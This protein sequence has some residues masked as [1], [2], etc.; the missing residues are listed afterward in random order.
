MLL[1]I[2]VYVCLLNMG[3]VV[4][5]ETTEYLEFDCRR[6]KRNL[7]RFQFIKDLGNGMA[8]VRN[9]NSKSGKTFEV[10]ITNFMM[11]PQS[12][13]TINK[14]PTQH[15]KHPASVNEVATTVATEET[16]SQED[17]D[18]DAGFD[19]GYDYRENQKKEQKPA[20]GSR[21]I[22]K[23]AQ[24]ILGELPSKNYVDGF[25]VGYQ[26]SENGEQK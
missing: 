4:L 5:K 1:L 19:A 11:N 15:A 18:W 21:E 16:S 26:N 9:T 20:D 25:K 14:P 6:I 17:E 22:E 23:A 12:P 13:R 7:L 3:L 2:L 10:S 24:E 8:L